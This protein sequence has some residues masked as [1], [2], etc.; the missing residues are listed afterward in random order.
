MSLL[1][2]GRSRV[3]RTL[4]M[5]YI[6]PPSKGLQRTLLNEGGFLSVAS[7]E[8]CGGL[9]AINGYAKELN[10]DPGGKLGD[11]LSVEYTR[12]LRGVKQSYGPPSP[13][14]SVYRGEGVV[15]GKTTMAARRECLES[16]FTL[17]LQHRGEPPD[18]ISLELEFMRTLCTSSAVGLSAPQRRHLG[19]SAF[20]R[21]CLRS[22]FRLAF[23]NSSLPWN[24][25]RS[26]KRFVCRGCVMNSSESDSSRPTFRFSRSA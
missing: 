22:I 24:S 20:R 9:K 14:E 15:L 11:S 6:H 17:A 26:L 10:S 1:A 18:H 23:R 5:I 21:A 8:L 7:L 13:Y 19:T 4:S 2:L 3:Y 12:L 25:L 16:C